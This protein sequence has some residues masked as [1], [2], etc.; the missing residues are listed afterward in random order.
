MDKIV[1]RIRKEHGLSVRVAEACG[2]KR[3]AVYQW[4]EVPVERAKI[5]AKVLGITPAE[6][7]PDMAELFK[8]DLK[9]KR[10]R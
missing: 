1:E 2:I 10:R 7:R 6:V 3:T 8:S 9:P 5:V 4:Q